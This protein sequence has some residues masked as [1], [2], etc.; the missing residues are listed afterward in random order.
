MLVFRQKLFTRLLELMQLYKQ[1]QLEKFFIFTI[2]QNYTLALTLHHYMENAAVMLE[3]LLPSY[4]V[5]GYLPAPTAAWRSSARREAWRHVT[6]IRYS[7]LRPPGTR[8]EPDM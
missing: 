1:N 8:T 5:R 3:N 7:S 4:L 2:Y 6:R